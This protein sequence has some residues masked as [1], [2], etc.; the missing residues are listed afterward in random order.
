VSAGCRSC[1]TALHYRMID[2]G[3]MPLANSY[4]P[5]EANASAEPVF[6]LEV[7]VCDACFLVQI[8]E[9]VPPEDI[10]SEY[11]YFSSYADTWV[12]TMRSYAQDACKELNLGADSLVVEVASNDGYLLRHFR[13]MGIPVLGVEPAG[14]VAEAAVA[15]GIPTEV[16]FFGLDT[17]RELRDRGVAADLLVGNNVLAH[18]PA[19]N[20]FV[21]GVATLLRP[22][23]VASFEFPHLVEMLRHVQFDTI[24]HEHCFYLS[25]HAVEPLFARH[26]LRVFDVDRLPTHGGSLRVWVTHVDGGPSDTANLHQLRVDEQRA[27]IA[28]L[29]TYDAFAAGANRVR[30]ALLA[31]LGEARRSAQTV[32]GYGAAAKGNTLLNYCGVGIDDIPFVVDRSA[33]KQGMRLPGSHIP[34]HAPEHVDSARPQ[35]VLILPWNLAPEVRNQMQR[36]REWGGRFVVAVP[37]LRID[38]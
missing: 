23:G 18:V 7:M 27:G 36:I 1:G 17:A 31:F 16:R 15:A 3:E 19:I 14:N 13:D 34:I 38:P 32:V 2:L 37:E 11:A 30:D 35:Y 28:N 22:G 6:G 12:E 20:D 26:G 9:T 21:A 24:Y 33:Y 5:M 10:F 8:K 29:E 25:L 4:L